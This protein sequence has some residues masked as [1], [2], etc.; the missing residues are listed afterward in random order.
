MLHTLTHK[1]IL[2]SRVYL[3][4]ATHYN[5]HHSTTAILLTLLSERTCISQIAEVSMLAYDAGGGNEKEKNTLNLIV[6][7]V[8]HK[9]RV[10]YNN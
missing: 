2:F 10:V 6:N 4:F 9:S 1:E 7:G 8:V 5:R 3:P